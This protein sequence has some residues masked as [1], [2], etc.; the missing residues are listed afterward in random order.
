MTR[1]IAIPCIK[2][3]SHMTNEKI[4]E[5]L[6]ALLANE[7]AGAMMYL[8]YSFHIYGHARIPIVGWLREQASEGM[9]HATAVGDQVVAFGGD[10]ATMPAKGKFKEHFDSLDDMLREAL[11]FEKET[12][13]MYAGLL[14]SISDDD[15]DRGALMLR[16]FLEGMIQEETGHV[17]EIEKMLRPDSVR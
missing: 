7:L 9:T 16:L 2:P 12:F 13:D 10:P 14:K 1:R 8:H 11:R 15:K 3:L 4:C 5:H 6:N 17:Q